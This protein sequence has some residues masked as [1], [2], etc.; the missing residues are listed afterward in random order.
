MAGIMWRVF[1]SSAI[2]PPAMLFHRRF[3]LYNYNVTVFHKIRHIYPAPIIQ[4][5][6][7]NPAINIPSNAF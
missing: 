6:A 5:A 7:E 1:R 3:Y 2:F 4:P